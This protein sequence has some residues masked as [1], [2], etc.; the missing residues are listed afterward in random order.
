MVGLYPC[1][2]HEADLQV[3]EEALETRNHKQISTD[4]LLKMAQFVLKT[5]FFEL[6]N[7]IFQQITGTAIGAK[8]AP[9]YAC[10]FMDQIETTFLRTQSHQPMVW[11]RCIED[12]FLFG[13]MEKKNLKSLDFKEADFN[14]FNLNIKFTYDSSKK[15]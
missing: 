7:D 8:L 11:F 13:L 6:N 10:I 15:V 14:A 2:P 5:N 12:I 9:P 4:N 3:L 1:I